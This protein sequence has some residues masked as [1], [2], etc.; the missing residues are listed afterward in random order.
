[1]VL[2][3]ELEPVSVF[4]GRGN[5]RSAERCRPCGR[6]RSKPPPYRQTH[7]GEQASE[8]FRR[9]IPQHSFVQRSGRGRRSRAAGDRSHFLHQRRQEVSCRGLGGY[10]PPRNGL[11]A[12]RG[13]SL[14]WCRMARLPSPRRVALARRC[15]RAKR[16]Y[17]QGNL[18]NV[19]EFRDGAQLFRYLRVTGSGWARPTDKTNAAGKGRTKLWSI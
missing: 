2:S 12:I 14:C 6:I 18:G 16:S 13:M 9:D 4:V 8:L 1:M 11:T 7:D 15:R 17:A 10:S 5:D 3:D 19:G